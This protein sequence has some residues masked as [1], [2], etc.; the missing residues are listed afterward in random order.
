MKVIFEV[1]T[2]TPAIFE[3]VQVALAMSLED[4]AKADVDCGLILH[5]YLAGV[6]YGT[7]KRVA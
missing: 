1:D 4:A 5:P 3:V 7:W 6:S 2:D